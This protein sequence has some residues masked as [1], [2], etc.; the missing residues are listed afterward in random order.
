MAK[1]ITHDELTAL[2]GRAIADADF[3][4]KLLADPKAAIEADGYE[5]S[6]A[7]IRFFE[8]LHAHGFDTAA[9]K[10]K[11]KGKHDPVELAGDM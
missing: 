2:L 8:S 4:A 9:K 6:P 3:R 1:K 5:A 11:V 10:V 7:A